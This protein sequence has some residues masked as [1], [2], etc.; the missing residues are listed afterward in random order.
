MQT[1]TA[2]PP[3][4]S[5]LN[6]AKI[7]HLIADGRHLIASGHLEAAAVRLWTAFEGAVRL[8]LNDLGQH[9]DD[10]IWISDTP[11]GLSAQ[12]VA[13]GVIDP[14]D[15]DV[16]LHFL[17][18]RDAA[19]HG[20]AEA[21]DVSMLQEVS[22]FA[23]RTLAEMSSNDETVE[24]ASGDYEMPITVDDVIAF[25]GAH[26]GRTFYTTR[27]SPFTVVVNGR[28]FVYTL[29]TG[30]TYEQAEGDM[31][32]L[33]QRSV[34]LNGSLKAKDYHYSQPEWSRFSSY[35]VSLM[36][37]LGSGRSAEDN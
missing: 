21:I 7:Q 3:T 20:S 26:P 29:S 37:A 19:A 28:G 5:L 11:Y 27:Q 23:E 25:I 14:E 12:A 35:F 30:E 24:I 22:R 15:R 6:A 18:M 16:L 2:P 4:V 36:A 8:S 32:Q 33:L 1:M 31:A 10:P 13:Y 34:E 17:S 9:T